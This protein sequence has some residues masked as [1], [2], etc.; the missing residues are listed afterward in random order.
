M[1]VE[2]LSEVGVESLPI[3]QAT[4]G[5]GQMQSEV[6]SV[7]QASHLW[8]PQFLLEEEANLQQASWKAEVI[9][10]CR[11]R[12]LPYG[13]YK[14]IPNTQTCGC[15]CPNLGLSPMQ[16]PT[17]AGGTCWGPEDSQKYR[18]LKR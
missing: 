8:K 5:L 18:A 9:Y 15:L 6:G 4:S 12:R 13:V 7:G 11:L 17:V 16:T 2:L 3:C 14:A 10:E 1:E